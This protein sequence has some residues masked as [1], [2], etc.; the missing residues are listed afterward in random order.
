VFEV[1]SK[2]FGEEMDGGKQ[3]EGNRR[4]APCSPLVTG[5]LQCAATRLLEHRPARLAIQL[6]LLADSICFLSRNKL[7]CQ[8]KQV[9]LPGKTTYFR[10]GLSRTNGSSGLA[11]DG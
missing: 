5:V 2:E 10:K 7:N 3:P 1:I 6:V 11:R 8:A 4:T 9:V